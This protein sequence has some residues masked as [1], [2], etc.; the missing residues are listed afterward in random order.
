MRFFEGP[1]HGLGADFSGTNSANFSLSRATRIRVSPNPS[2]RRIP[3]GKP[4]RSSEE[5][6]PCPA[7]DIRV[8]RVIRVNLP[9]SG[10]SPAQVSCI[11]AAQNH[12][13]GGQNR[14]K[15]AGLVS[16]MVSRTPDPGEYNSARLQNPSGKRPSAGWLKVVFL[17]IC[18]SSAA[19]SNRE[20]NRAWPLTCD[21][22]PS[23]PDP[24][25]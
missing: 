23:S 12:V 5:A 24:F 2:E 9:R 11:R 21:P 8:I 15:P 16:I 1:N 6:A 4:T 20:I 10:S 7:A 22:R 19:P 3:V 18:D 14:F 25:R 17:K 13:W